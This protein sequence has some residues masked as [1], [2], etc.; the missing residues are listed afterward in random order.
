MGQLPNGGAA[1]DVSIHVP[2]FSLK[3]GPKI[4]PHPIG[5]VGTHQ[6]TARSRAQTQISDMFFRTIHGRKMAQSDNLSLGLISTAVHHQPFVNDFLSRCGHILKRKLKQRLQILQPKD[7]MRI[8]KRLQ[9]QKPIRPF[10]TV[11]GS[12]S[13][14]QEV[15][16]MIYEQYT[17][18]LVVCQSEG[19][20]FGDLI[21]LLR[22]L[23]EPLPIR[24][25]RLGSCRKRRLQSGQLLPKRPAAQ[26]DFLKDPL[27]SFPRIPIF[28]FDI[29]RDLF[30]RIFSP[31]L[32]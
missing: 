15:A 27:L 2:G 11:R 30:K 32:C 26:F 16:S 13:K 20:L 7:A 21:P 12:F 22:Q 23:Q 25:K 31:C 10:S 17:Q 9:F 14:G 18:F 19:D 1:R 4:S 5:E 3:V 29:R 24:N 6:E 28:V 8:H